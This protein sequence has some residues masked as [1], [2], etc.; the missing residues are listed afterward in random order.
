MVWVTGQPV[1]DSSKKNQGWVGYFSGQVGSNQEILTDFAISA[2]NQH[3]KTMS[4]VTLWVAWVDPY[5]LY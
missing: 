3:A 1:F 4:L 5:F 2:I